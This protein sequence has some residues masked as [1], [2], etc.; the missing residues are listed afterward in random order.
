[1]ALLVGNQPFETVNT[2]PTRGCEIRL[3]GQQTRWLVRISDRVDSSLESFSA[4]FSGL[5]LIQHDDGSIEVNDPLYGTV[6]FLAD[7]RVSA[8]NRTL[9]PQQW[10][11]VGSSRELPL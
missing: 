10:S 8:E 2:G 7:G 5:T 3:N 4:C 6:R 1:M 11:V 9:D